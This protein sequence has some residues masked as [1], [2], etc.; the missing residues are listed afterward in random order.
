MSEQYLIEPLN[1]KHKEKFIKFA[2]QFIGE[3]YFNNDNFKEQIPLS[4]KDNLNCSFVMFN[5][6][7]EIIAIRLTYAP[8]VWQ[9]KITTQ[10]IDKLNLNVKKVAYF[11]SLFVH[12]D[13]QGKKIGPILSKKSIKVLKLMDCEYIISHSWLES[14][15]NSSVKYLEKYGFKQLGVISNFW[16]TVDYICTGCQKTS[17]SCTAVEMIFKI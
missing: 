10:H 3:N 14:P 2:D 17:C 6:E 13:Y 16:G 1:L 9:N 5:S 12:P 8:G 15:N 11:K 4:I 7:Q